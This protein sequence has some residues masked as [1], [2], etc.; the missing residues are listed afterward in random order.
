MTYFPHLFQ[1]TSFYCRKLKVSRYK[2]KN[3]LDTASSQVLNYPSQAIPL[4]SIHG[5]QTCSHAR[6]EPPISL[7][8]SRAFASFQWMFL[9][10]NCGRWMPATIK[11]DTDIMH[12]WYNC[13]F[14][15]KAPKTPSYH[16]PTSIERML[17]C[18]ISSLLH[19]SNKATH[20]RYD[21]E[22][23]IRMLIRLLLR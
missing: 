1:M 16:P 8:W 21:N 11:N 3:S 7:H 18:A 13:S 23:S 12:Q 15:F 4:N 17:I 10:Y 22:H 5:R 19:Q 14:R 6:V 2:I 9:V 20:F